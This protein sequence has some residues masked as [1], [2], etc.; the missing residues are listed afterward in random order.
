VN[1]NGTD[2]IGGVG[3]FFF[4]HIGLGTAFVGYKQ[5]G[6]KGAVVGGLTGIGVTFAA[7]GALLLL[8]LTGPVALILGGI[9]SAFGGVAASKS[10]IKKIFKQDAVAQFKEN[11]KKVYSEEYTKIRS[12]NEFSQKIQAEVE[13]SFNALRNQ[14]ESDCETILLNNEATLKQ[15]NEDRIKGESTYSIKR[16]KYENIVKEVELIAERTHLLSK[17]LAAVFER[18]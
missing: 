15:V 12:N 18:S 17:K 11:C 14:I 9:A 16:E 1:N 4:G 5:A 8:G 6:V 13:Q 7:A 10:I 3:Q 2:L